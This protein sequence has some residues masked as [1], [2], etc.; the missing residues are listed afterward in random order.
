MLQTIGEVA[1]RIWDYLLHNGE[2]SVST[3]K[4]DL[5]LKSDEAGLALG[6]LAREGKLE[7]QKKGTSTKVTLVK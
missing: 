5:E 1:G 2:T 4:K 7:F 3:L 6:W